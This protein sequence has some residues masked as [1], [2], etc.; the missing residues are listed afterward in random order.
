MTIGTKM[1]KRL[2]KVRAEV[3]DRIKAYRSK[4]PPRRVITITTPSSVCDEPEIVDIVINGDFKLQHCFAISS[5]LQQS[6][7]RMGGGTFKVIYSYSHA[8]KR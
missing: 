1:I 5:E 2:R 7:D 8:E 6:H 4:E 3:M